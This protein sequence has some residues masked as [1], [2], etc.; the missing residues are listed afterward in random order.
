MDRGKRGVSEPSVSA[1]NAEAAFTLASS[2][3]APW[4]A[5]LSWNQA[6]EDAGAP[7]SSGEMAAVSAVRPSAPA[8]SFVASSIRRLPAEWKKMFPS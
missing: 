6:G 3:A 2:L 7:G 4:P 8:S 5:P 1:L